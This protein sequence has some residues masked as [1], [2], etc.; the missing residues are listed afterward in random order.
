MERSL[1]SEA[2]QFSA[3]QEIPCILQNLK[4]HN[5]IHT[6]PPPV[7]ILSQFDPVHT[8]TSYILKIHLITVFPSMPESPKVVSLSS[9]FPTKTLYTPLLSSY[10]SRPSHSPQFYQLYNIGWAVQIIKLS[11]MQ[12]SPLSCYLMPPRPKYSPK[13]PTLIIQIL[14]LKEQS[15]NSHVFTV[16]LKNLVKNK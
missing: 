8:P 15:K 16:L 11:I 5:H 4:V 6:C 9:G 14:K 7:P 12:L 13:N 2:D 3:S 1:S 10:V